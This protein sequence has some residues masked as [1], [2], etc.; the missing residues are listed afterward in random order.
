MPGECT[1]GWRTRR[2]RFEPTVHPICSGVVC[3][4]PPSG[5]SAD[6]G[7]SEPRK[8][9]GRKV[10]MSVGSTEALERSVLESKDREQLLAI[11]PALGVKATSRAKKADII[12][13]IL[14]QT[15][16]GRPTTTLG[17]GARARN[18]RSNGAAPAAGGADTTPVESAAPELTLVVT[19]PARRRGAPAPATPVLEVVR[20]RR[21]AR[22][23]GAGARRRHDRP[24]RLAAAA[25]AHLAIGVP[26][27]RQRRRPPWWTS[28]SAGERRRGRRARATGAA[29][30]ATATATAAMPPRAPSAVEPR[31]RA[32]RPSRYAAPPEALP[33]R[34][35]RRR[36]ATSTSAT[37]ATASCG[38]TATCR[39][40][41]T[42]TSR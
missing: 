23:V 39:A 28:V 20:R 24:A 33:G 11:A 9:T 25:R 15:G 21:A 36:P 31:R 34:A 18:G 32:R 27:A 22:R 37:R 13:K 26:R 7:S 1:G 16:V 30:A 4:V 14:E 6:G 19:E 40:A 29:G 12:G 41:T 35:R 2:E 38:S 8:I 10:L 3:R 17:A 42:S 5:G